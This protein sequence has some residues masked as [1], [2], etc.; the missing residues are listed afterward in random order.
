MLGR[1]VRR[2]SHHHKGRNPL[3]ITRIEREID[4]R[5]LRTG[6][7]QADRG[8]LH[9]LEWMLRLLGTAEDV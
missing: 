3:K 8:S 6:S 5:L 4:G 2:D 9:M 1:V 7:Q